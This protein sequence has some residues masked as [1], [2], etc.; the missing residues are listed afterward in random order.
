MGESVEIPI[1]RHFNNELVA[2]PGDW[3]GAF[4]FSFVLTNA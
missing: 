1:A 2:I 4:S 3:Y